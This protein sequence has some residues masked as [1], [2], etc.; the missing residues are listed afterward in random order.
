MTRADL[1]NLSRLRI[2][3]AKLLLGNNKYSGAY[4]LAGYSIEC[5]LKACISRKI[6][7]NTIPEKKFII[8]RYTHNLKDLVELADLEVDRLRLE[9][10]R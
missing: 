3:K 7:A 10:V 8:D 4:Y 6:P 9:R 2:N 5:A 1:K